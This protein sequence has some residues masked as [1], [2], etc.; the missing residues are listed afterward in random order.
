MSIA[1]DLERLQQLHQSGALSDA[2]FA[3]AKEKLLASGVHPES[4][5]DPSLQKLNQFRRSK[6]D[7]WLGG[8]CGGL[9]RLT[10][11]ESWIWRLCFVLF[12]FYFGVGLIIYLLAWIFVP[13]EA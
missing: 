3:R 9:A 8:V 13:E 6:Q 7:Q 4:G 10:G 12:S 1:D 5:L 11:M 2:E